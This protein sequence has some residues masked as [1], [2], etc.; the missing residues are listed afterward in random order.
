M[1]A[2]TNL[3]GS[4]LRKS[5]PVDRVTRPTVQLF[6]NPRPRA[7]TRR[8][9]LALRQA[10]ER[11]GATI[12]VTESVSE[13]LE[14]DP[15]ADHVC[16]AGGDGTLRHV[17]DAVRRSGRHVSVSAFPAGTVNLLAM[18]CGYPRAPD[19]FVRRVFETTDRTPH[20]IGLIGETP[21]LVCASVGPDS[22]VVAALS[23]ARKKLVGRAAYLLAFCSLLARWPRASISIRH[24]GQQLECEAVYIAKGRYFAGPWSFA[25][26][27]SV[28]E[29][30][31]R[32]VTLRR[33]SR[34][35]FLCFASLLLLRRPVASLGG[36]ECF[37]CRE[38]E[39]TSTMNLPVQADGDVVGWLPAGVKVSSS[40]IDFA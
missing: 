38:L 25:P 5:V 2:S 22:Q 34:W 11:Y 16:S 8:R 33:A 18:E 14:I 7:R 13:R 26:D 28:D 3:S 32:V 37:S 39:I 36:V 12:L 9:I 21:M 10:L 40:T 4:S 23:P 6:V 20:F 31:L 1:D 35:Q 29:P 30:V 24:D 27:A 17:V 19:A 15:R